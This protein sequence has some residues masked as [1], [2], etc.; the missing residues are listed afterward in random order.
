[1]ISSKTIDQGIHG[2]EALDLPMYP[3]LYQW[4]NLTDAVNSP[5][6]KVSTL[7]SSI[8]KSEKNRNNQESICHY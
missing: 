2:K 6:D 7:K 4:I 1:M 3:S 5:I 8:V